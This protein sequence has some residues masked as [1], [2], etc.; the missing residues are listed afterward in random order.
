MREG[1]G[2]VSECMQ[3]EYAGKEVR[4]RKRVGKGGK[5]KCHRTLLIR[6]APSGP[7]NRETNGSTAE[8]CSRSPKGR[9]APPAI[10]FPGRLDYPSFTIIPAP[11]LIEVFDRIISRPLEFLSPV[12]FRLLGEAYL[13]AVDLQSKIGS[14]TKN[15]RLLNC[16]IEMKRYGN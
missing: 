12:E 1:E 4:E 10:R 3:R 14:D 5:R 8:I 16:S 13:P 6:F 11:R 9:V 15:N 2:G 7:A